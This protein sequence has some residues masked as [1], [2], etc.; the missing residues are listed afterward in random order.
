MPRAS[1]RPGDR[2]ELFTQK[3]DSGKFKARLYYCDEFGRRRQITAVE[4]TK[5]R[6]QTALKKKWHRIS[7]EMKRPRS[8]AASF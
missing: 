4:S 1:L 3:L 8:D 7:T 2:G 6:A 5:G